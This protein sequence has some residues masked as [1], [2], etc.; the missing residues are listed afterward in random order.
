MSFIDL[1]TNVS[2]GHTK[3]VGLGGEKLWLCPTLGGDKLDISGNG[4]HGT[5]NGGMG[6]VAD[7]TSG[8][9]RAYLLDGLDDY[10]RVANDL[11]FTNDFA[12]SA[13]LRSDNPSIL[14]G[15]AG[16]LLESSP[17]PQNYFLY[18]YSG[19]WRA[20]VKFSGSSWTAAQGPSVVSGQWIHLVLVRS[21]SNS[22]IQLYVNGSLYDTTT[23]SG[24]VVSTPQM[25]FTVGARA[26]SSTTADA[27]FNG[28]ADDIRVFDRALSTSEIKHLAS[29]RGVLGTPRNP[30][31]KKR[32]IFY[33]P[34]APVTTTAKAV[35]LKK[36]KPSYATGYARNASES[37]NPN[38]WKGLVGAWMPSFGVTGETL[39]DV[40]GNGNDG[41]LTN[42]DAASDWVATSKGLALDFDGSNDRVE[43]DD[44]ELRFARY[45]TDGLSISTWF[46]K[47]KNSGYQDLVTNRDAHGQFH[48]ILYIHITGQ[49]LQ[50]HGLAQY[51][52]T[53]VPPLNQW[54][55]VVATVQNNIYSL[56]ADGRLVQGPIA[57]DYR[58]PSVQ[59]KKL[60]IGGYVNAGLTYEPFGGSIQNTF[61]H[62][63]ALSPTE[64][65]QLYL[66]PSAPFER[67]QQT[68]GISTAQAFNPYWAN[69]ATQLAGTLQ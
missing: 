52:S 44:Q 61:I 50:L 65:K 13:Y 19:T 31:I 24:S 15:G 9:S 20:N 35:V 29:K 63:R 16:N 18:Q 10:I 66:N 33:A 36:P 54:T 27:F 38:L 17:W 43:V 46:Y 69:Q 3:I 34:T 5:Y 45:G 28:R 58:T 8:G 55:H 67:K 25:Y 47:T 32:R 11:T 1:H 7:T 56:Y 12:I 40:S 22:N 60:Q 53:Y 42:M 14:A 6:T 51:K 57:Y 41:T 30:V 21:A 26:R 4:N 48:Y 59:P 62:N 37:A 64:I 39:R 23:S 2:L 49:T 68:V